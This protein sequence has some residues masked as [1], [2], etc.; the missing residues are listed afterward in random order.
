LE[1]LSA[2]Q[3]THSYRR[4]KFILVQLAQIQ[5]PV[6]TRKKAGTEQTGLK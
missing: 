2:E 1:D 5:S 4:E 3:S 6:W